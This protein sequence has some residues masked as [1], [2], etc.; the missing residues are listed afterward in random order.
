MEEGQLQSAAGGDWYHV[1]RLPYTLYLYNADVGE[2]RYFDSVLDW[3]D[4]GMDLANTNG[5][6]WQELCYCKDRYVIVNWTDSDPDGKLRC[7][8]DLVLK[9]L[10]TGEETEY[11]VEEVAIDLVVSK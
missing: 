6:E 8:D 7:D 10:R 5:T 4:P 3:D 11:Q 2:G 1:D 9:N